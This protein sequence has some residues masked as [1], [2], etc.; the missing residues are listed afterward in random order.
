MWETGEWDPV[1][2]YQDEVDS[3]DEEEMHGGD[4]RGM[5][6]KREVELDGGTRE[7]GFWVEGMEATIRVERR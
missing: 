3:S 6:V 5:W 7:V 2:D 1:A 4:E